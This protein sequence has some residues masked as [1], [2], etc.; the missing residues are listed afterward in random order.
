MTRK[1]GNGEGSVYKR[2]RD[3]RWVACITLGWKANGTPDR[4]EFVRKTRSEAVEAM[5]QAKRDH[6]EGKPVKF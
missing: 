2:E 3:G 1:R 5:D 6:A 4:K